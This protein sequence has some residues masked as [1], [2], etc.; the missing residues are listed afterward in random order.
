MNACSHVGHGTTHIV[1]LVPTGR[2]PTPANPDPVC[3]YALDMTATFRLGYKNVLGANWTLLRHRWRGRAALLDRELN[4]PGGADA[5]IYFFV[6]VN[7]R[8]ERR[9][10][11]AMLPGW[12]VAQSASGRNDIYSD[13][14]HHRLI[15]MQELPLGTRT[16]QE[17]YVTIARYQHVPS[18][19]EW[20]GATAHLSSSAGTTPAKAAESREVQ[21]RRLAELCRGHAVDVL[22]ADIN[23][24]AARPRTPRAVLEAAGYVDWRQAVQVE[25]VDHDLHHVIGHALTQHGRHIDAIYL[26]PRVAV[27]DGRVLIDHPDSSDHLGLVCTVS[28]SDV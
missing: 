9:S 4:G 23:N 13:P 1:A 27:L 15:T 14:A 3:G 24:V 19:I 7:G 5:S 17:R 20:T 22:A 8:R 2:R 26:S 11:A 10:L 16:K 28:I 18:G 25:N 6:E 21:A 12:E